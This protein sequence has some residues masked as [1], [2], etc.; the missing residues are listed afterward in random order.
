MRFS[1]G[2]VGS[3]VF[4]RRFLDESAGRAAVRP[5]MTKRIV[6]LL[7]L[8]VAAIVP[9]AASAHADDVDGYRRPSNVLEVV[10]GTRRVDVSGMRQI[11]E[12]RYLPPSVEVLI[13]RG[14]G[15]RTLPQL[16][17]GLRVLDISRTPIQQLPYLPH[18]IVELRA[19]DG[20]LNRIGYLPSGLHTLDV[21]GSQIQSLPNLP[22][23]L[24]VLNVSRTS[25]RFLPA[26]PYELT[27]L[28]A[29]GTALQLSYV[30]PSV[31]VLELPRAHH[32]QRPGPH[33]RWSREWQSRTTRTTVQVRRP[34]DRWRQTS[35]YHSR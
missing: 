15:V 5:R 34:A 10:P 7:A 4:G 27:E 33:R 12:I 29:W 6:P 18:A 2:C 31:R 8:A 22:Y 35:A 21:S 24:H 13:L 17:S 14:T 25:I 32:G 3:F 28:R 16:P 23:R 19:R 30:P 20:A 1:V 26:L 9:G 11:D